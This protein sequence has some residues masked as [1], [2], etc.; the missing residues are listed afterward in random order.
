M[1]RRL[2]VLLGLLVLLVLDHPVQSCSLCDSRLALTPTIRQ[3]AGHPSARLI[4]L[5]SVVDSRLLPGEKAESTLRIKTV[6]RGK[7]LAGKKEMIL[8]RY[9]PVSDKKNPP[10]YL[11]YADVD[12]KQIDPYRGVRIRTAAAEEYVKKALALDPRDTAGN[13][14]FF[15]KY[16]DASDP[17]VAR[18]A[19]LE[20][21]KATDVDILK[22]ASR[23]D[24]G[25]LRGWLNDQKTPK[26]R[27]GLYA[28]L[29]GACGKAADADLLRKLLDGQE[30]RYSEAYDGILAGYLQRKPK[31]GWE[32]AH[33]ILADGKKPLSLRMAVLRT[34]RFY[35]AAQPKESRPNV[36]KAMRTV[37]VQ[38]EL[39]DL[40]MED[41]RTW[42]VWDLTKEVLACWGRKGFDSPLVQRAIL[43]YALSCQPT[44]EAKTFLARRRSEDP[45]LVKEVEEGLKLEK[46]S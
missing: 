23:L 46:G 32:L 37:L 40:A 24:A 45:D 33:A 20:F 17:E 2:I 18:D 31:E 26:E 44:T 8:P 12:G 36:L 15:F 22:A 19:F 6:Y 5:G 38:G 1:A 27:L 3:E 28:M 35:H 34:L 21:A 25:K 42:K 4:V 41:L 43:R 29:L 16:L 9:L 11:V 7:A 13:L 30:E 10:R 39:A 14:A